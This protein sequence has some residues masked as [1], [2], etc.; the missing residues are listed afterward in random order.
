MIP[1][2]GDSV[3]NMHGPIHLSTSIPEEVF[4]AKKTED[5]GLLLHTFG[6][7]VKKRLL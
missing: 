2:P 4:T 6:Y 3:I 1:E 5:V 7:S